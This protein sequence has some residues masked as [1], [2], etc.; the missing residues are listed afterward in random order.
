MNTEI[1]EQDEELVNLQAQLCDAKQQVIALAITAVRRM[2]ILTA[3][4]NE[5]IIA[6]LLMMGV[7]NHL[8][9][10]VVGTFLPDDPADFMEDAFFPPTS[11]SIN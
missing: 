8:M 6:K 3:Q 4:M 10:D 2:A 9:D 11:N 7:C 1:F 5:P